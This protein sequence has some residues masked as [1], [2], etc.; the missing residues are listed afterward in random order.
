MFMRLVRLKVKEGKLW[1]FGSFYDDRVI[2]ALQEIEGCLFACLLQQSGDAEESVSLTMWKRQEHA[3]AYEASGLYDQL[4]DESD[5]YL[6]ETTQWRV[7]LTGD[8]GRTVAPLQDPEVEA[9]PVEVAGLSDEDGEFLSRHLYLRIVAARIEAGRF[10]ELRDRFDKE[11][12][13]ELLAT[14]GCRAVFLVEGVGAGSRALSIT[15]WD[16]E[17]DAVRYELS[18][19]FDELTSRVSEFFS[20]LYQWKLSLAPSG[21]REGVSG[22]DLDVHGYQLVTGRRLRD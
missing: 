12:K 19:A 17:E 6:A 14:K 4:L 15:V 9:Y 16:R 7:Q 18:G 1:E 11:V 2:P 21:E 3:E 8:P 10:A 5:E 22:K 13:P 20:G